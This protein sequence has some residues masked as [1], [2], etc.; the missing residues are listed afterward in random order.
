MLATM[1]W[2]SLLI[3]DDF[4]GFTMICTTRSLNCFCFD[5]HISAEQFYD[6]ST[7]ELVKMGEKHK[8]TNNA[9]SNNGSTIEII[10]RLIKIKLY[11]H[12]L[13]V[14]INRKRINT[15]LPAMVMQW[16]FCMRKKTPLMNAS[17]CVKKILNAKILLGCHQNPT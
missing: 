3:S 10:D 4:Q 15:R 5:F 1:T 8:S 16:T 11:I 2:N 12:F 17:C 6:R 9:M 13:K 7:Q 14:A